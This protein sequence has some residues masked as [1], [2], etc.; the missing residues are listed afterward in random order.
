[1]HGDGF[2]FFRDGREWGFVRYD[3][4]VKQ[5]LI[6]KITGRVA[7]LEPPG[8]PIP[9]S[10]LIPSDSSLTLRMDADGGQWWLCTLLNARGEVTNDGG[11]HPAGPMPKQT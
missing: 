3:V 11:I 8:D 10:K 9:F 6:G 5:G 4:D 2:L 1:M 7:P